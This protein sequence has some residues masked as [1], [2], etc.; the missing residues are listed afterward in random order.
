MIATKSG[1]H[2]TLELIS[3]GAAGANATQAVD[4]LIEYRASRGFLVASTPTVLSTASLTHPIKLDDTAGTVNVT[5]TSAL[6]EE[7]TQ[8]MRINAPSWTHWDGKQ[9]RCYRYANGGY[10]EVER[11]WVLDHVQGPI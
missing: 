4:F 8:Q 2:V 10:V 9:G 6:D 5:N 3:E 11:E 1:A 7:Y